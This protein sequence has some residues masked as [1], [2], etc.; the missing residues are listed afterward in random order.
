MT[1]KLADLQS[2]I[3]FMMQNNVM[4]P[5]F[6]LEDTPIPAA[7]KD[8]QKGRKKAI[9]VVLQY[10][11]AKEHSHRPSQEVGGGESMRG[12][13]QKT[14]RAKETYVKEHQHVQGKELCFDT[15]NEGR[16]K[17]TLNDTESSAPK[18]LKSIDS[19]APGRTKEDLRDYL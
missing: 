7:K 14:P 19:R 15:I 6:P 11:K 18:S 13:S 17:R 8:A 3:N 1:N 4:Q 16:S 5:S 12:E 2:V 10:D 9:P